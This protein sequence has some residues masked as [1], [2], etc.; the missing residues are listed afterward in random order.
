MSESL[1]SRQ[2]VFSPFPYLVAGIVF[3]LLA[4][5]VQMPASVLGRWLPPTSPVPV[6]AWG[7]TVWHGQAEIEQGAGV[8]QLDW[9][10]RPLALLAGRIQLDLTTS[11]VAPL[12]GSLVRSPDM[13]QLQSLQGELP[14]SV[15]QPFL[16]RGWDLPGLV[17]ANGVTVAR[18]GLRRGD[19]LLAEGNLR[20]EGG[21]M[22]FNLNGQPKQ[23]TLPALTLVPQLQGQNL[24]L[25]LNEAAGSLADVTL[26]ADGQMETRLRERLLRYSPDYHS[27][28]MDP[29]AVVVTAK[30]AL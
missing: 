26:M 28:G 24:V 22:Q 27:G 9:Q 8:L 10:L 12:R 19:W 16:P 13:W 29:N 23:A 25:G 6:K 5:L 7:G 11:G 20:W 4:L 14:S 15:I 21:P 30:Q 2:E 3:L 18:Q 1:P 17:L